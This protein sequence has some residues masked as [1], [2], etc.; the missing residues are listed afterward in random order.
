MQ[1]NSAVNPKQRKSLWG[2]IT[3][4]AVI[5]K[6]RITPYGRMRLV[7]RHLGKAWTAPSSD[8]TTFIHHS[9]SMVTAELR[10]TAANKLEVDMNPPVSF[11]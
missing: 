9:S 5:Y 2:L 8:A 6:S 4:A 3:I 11:V 7:Q 1:I 10:W